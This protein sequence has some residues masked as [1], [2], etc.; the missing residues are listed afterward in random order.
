MVFL[1][2]SIFWLLYS[3]SPLNFVSIGTG[4]IDFYVF[5]YIFDDFGIFFVSKLILEA[6]SSSGDYLHLLNQKKILI[7]H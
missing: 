5:F 7:F 4:E 1:Y 6:I 3:L 2:S